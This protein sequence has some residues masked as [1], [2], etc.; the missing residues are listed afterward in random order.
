[1]GIKFGCEKLLTYNFV[2]QLA[3]SNKLKNNKYLGP[4]THYLYKQ[5]NYLVMN[6]KSSTKR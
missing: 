4:A 6:V 1:M 3:S 2:K 5:I